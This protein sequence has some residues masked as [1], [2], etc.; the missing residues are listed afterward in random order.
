MDFLLLEFMSRLLIDESSS[1]L[2][3]FSFAHVLSA[4]FCNGV[5]RFELMR[6]I[7]FFSLCTFS[8]LPFLV[9]L[10]HSAYFESL[11]TSLW[12]DIVFAL[13]LEVL[14]CIAQSFFFDN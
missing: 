6:V 2:S 5:D 12:T 13:E 7:F 9:C 3:A 8:V 10:E 1:A 4:L 14:L 11:I